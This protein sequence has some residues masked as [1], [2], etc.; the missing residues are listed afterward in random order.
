M[1]NIQAASNQEGKQTTQSIQRKQER[2][3]KA[4]NRKGSLMSTSKTTSTNSN[5]S[6]ITIRK[7]EW[8]FRFKDT[9]SHYEFFFKS[10][11]KSEHTT[12]EK[13]VKDIPEKY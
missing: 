8:L 6:I 3:K 13:I 10:T 12:V 7:R 2:I 5:K 11:S 9:K 4:K 1:F